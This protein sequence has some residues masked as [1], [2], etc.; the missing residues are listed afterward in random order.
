MKIHEYQGKELLR[1]YGVATP[2]G[3]ACFTVDETVAAAEKLG[4]DV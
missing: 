2:E 3:V 4:G 1:E